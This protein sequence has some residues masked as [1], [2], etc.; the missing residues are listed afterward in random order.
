MTNFHLRCSHDMIDR[1]DDLDIMF[2]VPRPSSSRKTFAF[3]AS[4]TDD[5]TGLFL[6]VSQLTILMKT[7]FAQGSGKN[8]TV[9]QMETPSKEKSDTESTISSQ[10]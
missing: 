6:H 3:Y 7:T 2:S 4:Y 9:E 8:E 5:T 1:L 10:C